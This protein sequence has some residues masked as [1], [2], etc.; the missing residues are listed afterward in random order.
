MYKDVRQLVTAERH[1]SVQILGFLLPKCKNFGF[2]IT[3]VYEF[4]FFYGT[5]QILGRH[6]TSRTPLA[7]HP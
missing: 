1:Q 3:K 5:V 4:W 2:F 7:V 6:V